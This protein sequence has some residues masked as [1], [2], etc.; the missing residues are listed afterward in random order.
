MTCKINVPE[1][2]IKFMGNMHIYGLA[3]TYY[4]Y[5]Y[6]HS[7]N[8]A[9]VYIYGIYTFPVVTFFINKTTYHNRPLI[10]HFIDDLAQKYLFIFLP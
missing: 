3:I 7:C 2:I 9:M 6:Y 4:W 8:L 1:A 10:C 5:Y